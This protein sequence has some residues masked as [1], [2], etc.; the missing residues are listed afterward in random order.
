MKMGY[1]ETTHELYKN[2]SQEIHKDLCCGDRPSQFL[3]ELNIPAEMAAMD[4]GCGTTV[5]FGEL[6]SDENV[7]YVGIGGGMEALQFAYFTRRTGSVIAVDRVPEMIEKARANFDI[8]EKTNPWFKSDFVN[9]VYGDALKLPLSNNSVD[10]AAQNCLFNIFKE[11]DLLKALQ[12]MNRVLKPGGKLYIS[13]P[14]TTAPIPE[15]LRNDERLRAMC[16]SGALFFDE[17]IQK[18][19][20]A[21]FGV[22]EIRARRPYRVLDKKQYSID[23]NIVLDTVELVAIKTPVEEDGV[24]CY[25]GETATYVGDKDLYDDNNG[26]ILRRGI[27]TAVCQKT[28]SKLRALNSE[29]ILITDPTYHYIGIAKATSNSCCCCGPAPEPVPKQESCDCGCNCC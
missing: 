9:I 2:A 3:P 28:A 22:I 8:A 25:A 1:L 5:H 26:H 13:D 17:Y 20:E 11:N 6:K 4:Y 15:K 12:E 23:Q 24:C 27:P 18:I 14:I 19:A 10:I 21:G 16:L 29:D 7:L